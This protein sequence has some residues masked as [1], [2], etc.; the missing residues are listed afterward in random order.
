LF[1]RC[2]GH[3]LQEPGGRGRWIALR[4]LRGEEV[5]EEDSF[6][7]GGG[8]CCGGVRVRCTELRVARSRLAEIVLQAL[9]RTFSLSRNPG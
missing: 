6:L 4:K 2:R 5:V 1:C 7:M 3:E 9:K 8:L